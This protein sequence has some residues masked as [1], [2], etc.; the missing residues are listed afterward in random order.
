MSL[1]QA[2]NRRPY[3]G[4]VDPESLER[5]NDKSLEDLGAKASFLKQVT[6]NIREEVDTQH[7]L[8]DNMGGGMNSVQGSL[9]NVVGRFKTV[10]E[11]KQKRKM[12]IIAGGIVV[13]FLLL[14]LALRK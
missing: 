11:D 10:M 14:W 1:G 4:S 9:G 6:Q 12:F 13:A 3:T 5:E 2:S 7:L 8:I